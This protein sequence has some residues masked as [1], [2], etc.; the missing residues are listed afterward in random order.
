MRTKSQGRCK[1]ASTNIRG[2]KRANF[3]TRAEKG[4]LDVIES[5]CPH[6]NH[7]KLF[8]TLAGKITCC[9]CKQAVKI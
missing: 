3:S 2:Q 1:I 9:K 7:H 6:C 8:S 5:K 4:N